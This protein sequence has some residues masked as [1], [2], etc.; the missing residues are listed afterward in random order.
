[1]YSIQ[2][3]NCEKATCKIFHGFSETDDRMSTQST[4]TRLRIRLQHA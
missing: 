2:Y 3:R 4:T 1:M